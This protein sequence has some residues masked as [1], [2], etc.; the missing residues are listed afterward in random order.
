MRHERALSCWGECAAVRSGCTLTVQTLQQATQPP[1]EQASY[2]AG[3][4]QS[5]DAWREL[6]GDGRPTCGHGWSPGHTMQVSCAWSTATGQKTSSPLRAA[7][8]ANAGT[9]LPPKAGL[10]ARSTLRSNTMQQFSPARPC[11]PLLLTSST[12]DGAG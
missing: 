1:T 9:Q 12:G 8:A 10:R 4:R 6:A 3:V 11:D 5:E 7:A 2:S